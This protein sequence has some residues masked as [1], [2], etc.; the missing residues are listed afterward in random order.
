MDNI[1]NISLVVCD[2]DGVLADGR[3]MY[4]DNDIELKCFNIKDGLIIKYLPR[5]GSSVLLL[6]GR[7][8]YAVKKRAH[9]LECNLVENA[10]NKEEVLTDYIRKIGISFENVAYIGDDLNDFSAMILCGYKACPADAAVEIREISD[11]I[12][13]CYGG[14][15]AVRDICEDILKRNG[16]YEML[17]SL[18][19]LNN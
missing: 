16:R 6:T 17:L 11:Y 3:I 2:V 19:G 15:G 13:P 18:F 1:N 9:E 4:G 10:T 12:S 7:S 5:L 14:Y 8:S